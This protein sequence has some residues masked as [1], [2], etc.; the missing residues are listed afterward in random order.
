[1]EAYSKPGD[2]I[3]DSFVGS[4][5]VGV[6]LKMGRNVIGYDVDHESIEFSQKRFEKYLE[7]GKKTSLSIAA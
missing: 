5:T 3:L 2:T 1:M 6:G 4:G 7:D